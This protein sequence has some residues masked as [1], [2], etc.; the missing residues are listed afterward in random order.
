MLNYLKLTPNESI[1]YKR[2]IFEGG[3]VH[4]NV[5]INDQELD[6]ILHNNNH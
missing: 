2:N 5:E 6:E 1:N 3:S 4:E